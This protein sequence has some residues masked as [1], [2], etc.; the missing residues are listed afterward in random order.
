M[1]K[2][3]QA[4]INQNKNRGFTLIELLV[5]ISIIGMLSSVVLVSL[6]AARDKARIGSSIIFS[7]SNYSALGATAGV[8]YHFD[9]AAGSTV[10][11][12]ASANSRDLTLVGNPTF[13]PSGG[14]MKGAISFNGANYAKTTN[15]INIGTSWTVS[16]WANVGAE[17]GAN[18]FLSIDGIW[19]RNW[20]VGGV[21]K[22][23]GS[24]YDSASAARTLNDI[25]PSKTGTWTL[26]TLTHNFTKQLTTLYID[27]KPV[28]TLAGVVSKSVTN[29]VYIGTFGLNP[30][31]GFY[32]TGSV[33]EA[34]VYTQALSAEDIANIYAQGLPRHSLASR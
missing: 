9:E 24:F 19:L 25:K 21:Y 13:L 18:I 17:N 16:A 27:G 2:N 5:V 29:D 31:G 15:P 3:K 28:D 26:V 11:V 20:N 4:P 7:Q 30:G 34:H 8:S 22:F 6:T 23:S 33:D 10:A 14:V 1:T 12:D 32:F